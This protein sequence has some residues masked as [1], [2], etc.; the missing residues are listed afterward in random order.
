MKEK[1]T[2][3]E[4]WFADEPGALPEVSARQRNAIM[5]ERRTENISICET[6]F[7]LG[8][9]VSAHLLERL[10]CTIPQAKRSFANKVF[11]LVLFFVHKEKNGLYGVTTQ[12]VNIME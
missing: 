3:K 2:E 6:A 10:D 7:R 4:L 11:L 1:G 12:Q 5:I 8:C 9:I